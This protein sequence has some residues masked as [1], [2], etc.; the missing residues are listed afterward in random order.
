MN[1][2]I[3]GYIG[4]N[5]EVCFYDVTNFYF[6]INDNDADV[7]DADGKVVR[8]GIRKKGPSK[9]KRGEPIV[10]MGLFIDDNGIPIAYHLFPGNHT[11]Q[12]TLRPALK[13]SIDNMKFKG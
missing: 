5:T 7:L 12:T 13:K 3:S 11:D 9:E 4:R 10:Q 2:K 8:E 1:T 6:E